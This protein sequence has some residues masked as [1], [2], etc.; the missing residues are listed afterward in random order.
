M[1]TT[2]RRRERETESWEQQV[3]GGKG[4]REDRIVGTTGRRRERENGRQNRGN[5]R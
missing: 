2:G 4:R 3:Q 5:N 1:A